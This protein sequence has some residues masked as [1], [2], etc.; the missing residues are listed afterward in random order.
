MSGSSSRR[1]VVTIS[2]RAE[3]RRPS[4]R[5]AQNPL[6]AVGHQVGDDAVD[7]VA[8]VAADL[9]AARGQ[10]L[11]GW[12]AVAGEVAVHVGG[13]GV[14]WR[15][16]VD[17]EDVAAGAGEDQGGGQAC[18]A[19]ADD[20]DVVLTHAPKV[21]ARGR[22]AY[23]RCCL[24]ESGVRWP[25]GGHLRGGHRRRARPGRGPAQATSAPSAA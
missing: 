20:R 7:D 21:E 15:A 4:A 11:G 3:I 13:R 25:R 8:A 12:H 23:E 18:G 16:R 19:S 1:P 22:F 17:H 24:W 5:R 2:R 9:V 10:Q 14:A 6:R